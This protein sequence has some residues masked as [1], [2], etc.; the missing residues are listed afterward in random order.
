MIALPRVL[1]ADTATMRLGVRLALDGF[2]KVCAEADDCEAAVRAARTHR[3]DACLIGTSIGDGAVNTVRAIAEAVPGVPIVVLS[4][5][6]SVD[7]LMQA[8]RAGAAG[9]V[10]AGAGAPQLR[11]VIEVVLRDEAAVPRS[12]MRYLVDEVRAIEFADQERLTSRESEI[13]TM[14]RRGHST[15]SIAAD[16]SISPITVR[17]HISRLVEKAGVRG[18][19]ELIAAGMAPAAA[20]RVA[21]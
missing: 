21:V 10:L 14:L 7:D 9:Y 18:R 17:R 1:V 11:R 20:E 16:L 15:A 19:A 3:P 5:R 8:L 13:L 12:M 4:G 6:D 2:A